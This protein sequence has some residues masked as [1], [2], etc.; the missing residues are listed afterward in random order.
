MSW[1]VMLPKRRK[2][3]GSCTAGG[4]GAR[5]SATA[6]VFLAT[7]RIVSFLC[8]RGVG[9][10]VCFDRFAGR[11]D[12]FLQKLTDDRV[13]GRGRD[14]LAHGIAMPLVPEPVIGLRPI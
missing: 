9:V 10:C 8:E 12:A 3:F 5:R 6:V 4:G 1:A 7:V 11:L 14:H 13:H 2:R